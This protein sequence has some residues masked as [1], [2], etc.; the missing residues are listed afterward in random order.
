MKFIILQLCAAFM[1]CTLAVA[2]Q[3]APSSQPTGMEPVTENYVLTLTITDKE[4]AKTKISLV[5]ALGIVKTGFFDPKFNINTFQGVLK[6]NENGA[7]SV[8]YELDESVEVP[9]TNERNAAINYKSISTQATVLLKLDEPV[10][11]I[12]SDSRTCTLSVSKLSDQ[13]PKGN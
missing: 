5:V 4:Q 10:Q 12:K 8:T 2:Q 13:Q 1:F 7:V 3:P 6:S 9:A 11:I